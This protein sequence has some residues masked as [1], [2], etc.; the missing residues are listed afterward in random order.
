MISRVPIHTSRNEMKKKFT[1]KRQRSEIMWDLLSIVIPLPPIYKSEFLRDFI[2]IISFFPS[3][4]FFPPHHYVCFLFTMTNKREES[5]YE[6]YYDGQ[7]CLLRYRTFPL[8]NPLF[9]FLI[10]WEKN[11][12]HDEDAFFC[13]V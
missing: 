10:W 11:L 12:S 4:L 1:N 6:N 2:Q 13:S 3:T 9:M 7:T 5:E 8:W